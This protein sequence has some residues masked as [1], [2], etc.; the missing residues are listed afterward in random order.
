MQV[1]D[2]P[3]WWQ[4]TLLAFASFRVWRLLAEDTILDKSR[5]KL[6]RLGDWSEDSGQKPPADYRY[7]LG[8]FLTC[9]WCSGAW[10]GLGFWS[11]WMLWPHTTI[12]V[13]VPLAI[14]T[15][16]GFISRLDSEN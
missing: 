4:A 11:A 13:A 9:A 15:A 5:R 12:V 7:T 14:S 2:V 1:P 6:L 3:D 16:V 8:E 10:I